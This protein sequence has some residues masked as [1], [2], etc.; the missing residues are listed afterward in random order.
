MLKRRLFLSTLLFLPLLLQGCDL[1]IFNSVGPVGKDIG[2]T[3]LLTAGAMLIVVIPTLAMIIYCVIRYR[4]REDKVNENY[5]PEWEH[6]SKVELVAWG[7]P[8]L[9]IAFLAVVTWIKTHD[10]DPSKRLSDEQ[11]MV[12]NAVALN[13][14]WLFIYPDEKI[15]TINEL[16]LPIDQPVEFR[17]TSDATMNSLFIPRLGSQIYAMSGMENRVNLLA[18]ETG[19]LQGMSSMY[20]GYGFTGMHFDVHVTDRSEYNQWVQKVRNTGTPLNDDVF[21]EQVQPESR[22]VPVTYFNQADP[23]LYARII[24]QFAGVERND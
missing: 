4:H 9:I 19:K 12:V 14:K 23:G 11:P 5:H 24:N 10:L 22:N 2:N 13:W 6:S 17:V 16:Y 18:H 15:A 3:L 8:I 1:A 7:V 21:K 20:S